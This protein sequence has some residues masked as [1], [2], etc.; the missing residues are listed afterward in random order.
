M[1]ATKVT[2]AQQR[3]MLLSDHDTSLQEVYTGTHSKKHTTSS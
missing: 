2:E 1:P 3:T